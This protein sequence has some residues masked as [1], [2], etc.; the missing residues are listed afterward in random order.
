MKIDFGYI[1]SISIKPVWK[2]TQIESIEDSLKEYEE[3]IMEDWGKIIYIGEIS[4]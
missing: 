1:F 4:K 3:I 2:G